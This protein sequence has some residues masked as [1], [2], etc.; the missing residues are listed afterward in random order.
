ME[1]I[2]IR[3]ASEDFALQLEVV[4][5]NLDKIQNEKYSLGDATAAWLD[6][7]ARFPGMFFSPLG[8]VMCPHSSQETSS[9]KPLKWSKNVPSLRWMIQFSWQRISCP[10]GTFAT[11][12]A[13][14]PHRCTSQDSRV[15][16]LV[17][18]K[19]SRPQRGSR[20]KGS[21]KEP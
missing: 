3:R 9:G 2:T 8:S 17:P 13:C 10:T 1:N 20:G 11:P 16:A 19:F 21:K 15:W 5:T 18:I 12:L 4:A 14:P 7:L 6:V